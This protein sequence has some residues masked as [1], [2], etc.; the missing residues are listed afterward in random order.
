MDLWI[1]WYSAIR[2]LRPGFSREVTFL[3]FAVSVAGLSVRTDRLGI[4]SI[5]RALSLGPDSSY[6][7]LLK[8]CASQAINL[9]K[10]RTLWIALVLISDGKKVAKSGKKMPPVKLLHQE[11]ESNIKPTYIMGHSTQAICMLVNAA[12]SVLPAPRDIQTYE[13]VVFSNRD[14]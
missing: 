6:Q 3:W 2:Q 8:N 7:R 13:G 10:L 1:H 12:S 9:M 14:K 11:S 4:S 5:G